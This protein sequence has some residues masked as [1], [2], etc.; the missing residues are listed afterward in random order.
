MLL[1]A[2]IG[3]HDY[4]WDSGEL[5]ELST[6][7][8][9]HPNEGSPRLR[10][11]GAE[12]PT[13][14]PYRAG[15]FVGDTRRGGS[16]NV[17]VITVAPHLHGTHTESIGHVTDERVFV[18]Y[19]LR[20]A[21]FPATVISVVPERAGETDETSAPA[22]QQGDTLIT[23][24][25]LAEARARAGAPEGFLEAL[26]LRTL[27][28]EPSKQTADYDTYQPAYFTAEAM[29]LVVSWG[30]QHLVVDLPSLDRLDDG[31]ALTAH[32]IYWA[33]PPGSKTLREARRPLATV[34]ELAYVPDALRDGPVILHLQ[35]PPWLSDAAPSRIM[36]YVCTPE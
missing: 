6:S 28:N 10:L 35:V 7:V 9:F 26:V 15:D 2:S 33:L 4:V 25:A 14:E 1:R 30:V 12:A 27:P 20:E 13:A 3:G 16:V 34:S 5:I 8:A 23:A 11:F 18:S 24:R 29:A 21:M 17:E 36:A 22:P 31:G 19:V 32:R